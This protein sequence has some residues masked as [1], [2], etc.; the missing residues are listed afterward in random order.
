[1]ATR[2][3]IHVFDTTLRDGEQA[4]GLQH[5]AGREAAP[6]AAARS[7]GRGHHRGRL[8]DLLGRRLR[9]GARR[10][11]RRAAADHR[12]PGPRHP[13]RHRSRLGARCRGAARPRIHVFLATSDIHLEH[14]LRITRE[15]CLEQVSDRGGARARATAT[16]WSSRPK[17]PRAATSTSCARSPRPRSTPAPRPSTCPTPSATRC[18]PTSSGCSRAVARAR[19]RRAPC[20]RRTAT[21]TSGWRWPTRS[22]PCRPARARWSAPSTA[23]AS[24][25]A[26]RRSKRS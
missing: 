25:P 11:R 22:P 16:T 15:Q 12:R 8:P 18:P 9:G 21:T 2:S 19:R 1:M 17:T 7:P 23:S 4:P 3:R 24:A 6:G 14:K 10:R 5:D 13:G 20:C 26:T